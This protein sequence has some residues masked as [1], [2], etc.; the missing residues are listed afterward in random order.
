MGFHGTNLELTMTNIEENKKKRKSYKMLA[1]S[2]LGKFS[3]RSNFP[4][5]IYVKSKKDVDKFFCEKEIID[6][7]PI[8]E[9]ICELQIN[10]EN[11]LPKRNSNCIIGAFI[12]SWARIRLHEDMT[13]LE[14]SGHTLYYVDTDSIIFSGARGQE[15][16]LVRSPCL[17]DY[18]HE[19]GPDAHITSF[20]CLG[21]KN[22]SITY[23]EKGVTKSVVKI[24]GL[25]LQSKIAQEC[26]P[27]KKY[28]EMVTSIGENVPNEVSIPQFRKFACKDEDSITK[29]I[30][31]FRINNKVQVQRI[32]D[33][34]TTKTR[35]YGYKK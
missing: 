5:V 29:K 20:S 30:L 12:T 24:S 13:K 19:L 32:V 7:L 8:S 17:G 14:N 2:M 34:L 28:E 4:E 35:P 1:N 3:Q 9:D 16:P 10:Q 23:V 15:I 31:N 33:T 25:T 6:I 18:K 21:R 22:Y 11:P 27:G 26:L